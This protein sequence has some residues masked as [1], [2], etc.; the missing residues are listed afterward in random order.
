MACR[1]PCTRPTRAEPRRRLAVPKISRL[2]GRSCIGPRRER[3]KSDHGVL[4]PARY[5]RLTEKIARRQA[6][7]D[8]AVELDPELGRRVGV[9]AALDDG[10]RTGGE[11]GKIAG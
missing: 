3:R 5:C 10:V 6:R 7:A 4:D 8:I 2:P 11:P 9:G 1:P